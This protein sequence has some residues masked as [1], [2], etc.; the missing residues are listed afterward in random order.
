VPAVCLETLADVL[1]E[2]A[3]GVAVCE[4]LAKSS[5]QPAP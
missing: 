1:G 5:M 4:K 3:L 2:G